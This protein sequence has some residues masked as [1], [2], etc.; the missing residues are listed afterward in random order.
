MLELEVLGVL[1]LLCAG[2]LVWASGK[3]A[4]KW[5]DQQLGIYLLGLGMA[6]FLA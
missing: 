4:R 3:I 5:G 2:I 6:A 1:F